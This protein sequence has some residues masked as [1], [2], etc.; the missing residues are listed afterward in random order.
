MLGYMAK[1]GAI[2]VLVVFAV[3]SLTFLLLCI[4]PGDT[5]VTIIQRV[6]VGNPD[7][8]PSQAEIASTEK[9]FNLNDPLWTQYLRWLVNAA[10][11]D[12][13]ASYYSNRPVLDEILVKL[14]ATILLALSATALSLL[15]GIPL[16]VLSAARQNSLLDYSGLAL[17]TFFIAMPG[18][19]LGLILILVFSLK[20]DLLPVAGYGEL[21]HLILP[22]V[23]LAAGM[24][25]ITLRLT[26]T[27]VL[28]VLRLDYVRTARSKGLD[29]KTVLYRH[30]LKTP[31]CRWSPWWDCSW[32][33]CW[34]A[35]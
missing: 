31:W 3:A 20:L 27:S 8:I 34:A 17:S 24:T 2:A 1:R 30:V 25:A 7:Y 22:T 5:T 6:F 14:P 13:G 15:V 29:E 19:W 9:M 23:T 32:D 18:F 21:R 4:M 26:R 16:G 10:H 12:F 33:T 28:E 35:P 11:G